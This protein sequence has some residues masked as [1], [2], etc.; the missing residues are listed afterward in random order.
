MANKVLSAEGLSMIFAGI[1]ID[2]LTFIF[3]LIG[4]FTGIGLILAKIIYFLGLAF[5]WLWSKVRGDSGGGVSKTETGKVSNFI[6]KHFKEI[7]K[8]VPVLG[9]FYPAF[10]IIIYSK[11]KGK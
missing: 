2:S 6:K 10:T 5:I 7:F 4:L 11:L 3:S 9:D 1:V 8:A